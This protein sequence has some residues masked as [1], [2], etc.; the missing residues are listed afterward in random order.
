MKKIMVELSFEDGFVPPDNF[1]YASRRKCEG[2]PFYRWDFEGIDADCN[3][4]GDCETGPC[5][6]KK[7]FA[8]GV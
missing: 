1:D 4:L 2:C 5:P 8:E 6:I 7:Y 3:L